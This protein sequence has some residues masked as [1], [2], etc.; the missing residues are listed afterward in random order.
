MESGAEMFLDY[1]DPAEVLRERLWG[2]VITGNLERG[3]RELCREADSGLFVTE[4]EL[5]SSSR[6]F[7]LPRGR[8]MGTQQPHR[9]VQ[10][11]LE[12]V[13]VCSWYL[14]GQGEGA[15]AQGCAG[16]KP[17]SSR[18]GTACLPQGT[19]GGSRPAPSTAAPRGLAEETGSFSL[20]ECLSLFV[21]S[22]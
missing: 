10:G 14:R 13:T 8:A 16:E 4:R 5:G 12:S 21:R 7:L 20:S 1:S 6:L 17:P 15:A 22:V 3:R 18:Q 11:G 19:R 2:L 9:E